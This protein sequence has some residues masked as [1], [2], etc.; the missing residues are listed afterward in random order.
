M[1]RHA[2]H[3]L[4]VK[5]I[6]AAAAAAGAAASRTMTAGSISPLQTT[7]HSRKQRRA[8]Q[9]ATQAMDKQKHAQH[10]DTSG[11]DSDF[12]A[13]IRHG[14]DTDL[15]NDLQV[16]VDDEQELDDLQG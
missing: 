12:N 13:D 6:L 11:N 14:H 16:L 3:D 7:K 5:S 1:E 8:A 2:S 10:D 4:S 9:R 15:D